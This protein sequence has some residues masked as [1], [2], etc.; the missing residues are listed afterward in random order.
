MTVELLTLK[1]AK[2][3]MPP[4]CPEPKLM[5]PSPPASPIAALP[6]KVQ[7]VTVKVAPKSEELLSAPPPALAPGL[8]PWA[9]FPLNL[10]LLIVAAAVLSTKRLMAPP[11]AKITPGT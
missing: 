2:L 3:L 9:W 5:T 8:P 6:L 4:P 10:L 11:N 7:P 1:F